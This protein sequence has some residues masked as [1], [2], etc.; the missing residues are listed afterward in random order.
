[1]E[2][3]GGGKKGEKKKLSKLEK[4]TGGKKPTTHFSVLVFCHNTQGARNEETGSLT[5][6]KTLLRNRVYREC[7]NTQ[8]DF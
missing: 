7:R 6:Q 4:Q 1:M 8:N 3:T 2:E 5:K